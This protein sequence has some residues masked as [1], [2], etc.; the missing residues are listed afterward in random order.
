MQSN[1]A[2]PLWARTQVH[3]KHA[4]KEI[5]LERTARLKSEKLLKE[6]RIQLASAT[7]EFKNATV[8]HAGAIAMVRAELDL[9]SQRAGA[10]DHQRQAV[11]AELADRATQ[12]SE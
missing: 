12:R 10:T 2:Q 3:E 9:A 5:D 11:A 4:W 6:F 7:S 8:Q 1:R